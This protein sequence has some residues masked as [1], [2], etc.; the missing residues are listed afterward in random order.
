MFSILRSISDAIC[1]LPPPNI[2]FA[3]T[4]IYTKRGINGNL[5]YALHMSK[6]KIGSKAPAFKLE[7][8]NGDEYGL[9]DISSPYIVLFFYPKDNTPGCTI[10]AKAFTKLLKKFQSVD[11]EVIGISGGD[12]KSKAKFCE[13]ASLDVTLLSDSDGAVGKKYDTF[14]TKKFMGKTYEGFFRKTFVICP[15]RK[16]LHIFEDVKPEGHAEEVLAFLKSIS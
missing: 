6:I 3:K 13:K 5:N 1:K 9:K 10:E 12:Q 11:A 4:K 7:N 15:E 2:D 16:I 14:G 8:Q